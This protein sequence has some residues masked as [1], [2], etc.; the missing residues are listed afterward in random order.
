MRQILL[1][2]GLLRLHAST[3][4]TG[5]PALH[6]PLVT[7]AQF[8]AAQRAHTP[9]QR[10]SKDLLSGRVRCGLCD[11]VVGV[12]YNDGQ[13]IYR[14]KHRG[15]GCDVP[16]RSAKGLHRAALLASTCSART[17]S[18]RQRSALELSRHTAPC[19]S[20]DSGRTAAALN[21][22]QAKLLDLYYAD[23]ITAD[24]FAD[25]ERRLSTQL[26]ELEAAD[27]EHS[28]TP[29][30]PSWPTVSGKW[31]TFSPRSTSPPCGMRPTTGND[32]CSSR[33]WSTLCWS[34]PA[35]RGV[36][37]SPA[38]GRADRSRSAPAR[39]YGNVRVGGPTRLKP[40]WRLGS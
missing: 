27:T 19:E 16:G 35:G 22:K 26:A 31:P 3:Q 32:V 11:R 1:E 28:V 15:K 37:R 29:N 2:P 36:R 13:A 18:Y 14:C 33:T 30:A 6:E 38:Q 8:D 10:R 7:E 4:A 20:A 23:R 34:P 39:W 5:S 17:T 12:E 21:P 9:G 25:E 40:E 24:T